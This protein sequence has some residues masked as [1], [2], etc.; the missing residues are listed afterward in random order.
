MINNKTNGNSESRS[1]S[2][3]WVNTGGIVQRLAMENIPVLSIYSECIGGS[4]GYIYGKFS[5]VFVTKENVNVSGKGTS[6][7]VS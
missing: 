1:G 6:S 2:I 4:A 3:E 7:S 5:N